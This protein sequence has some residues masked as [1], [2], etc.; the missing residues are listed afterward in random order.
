MKRKAVTWL[1][2]IGLVDPDT[3][4]RHFTTVKVLRIPAREVT[5]QEARDY[6]KN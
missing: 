5:E 1:Q 2:S 3:M 6:L 4:L